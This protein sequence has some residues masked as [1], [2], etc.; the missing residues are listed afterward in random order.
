MTAGA[1]TRGLTAKWRTFTGLPA[2]LKALIGLS[3]VVALGSYM[4]TP[5]IGVLMVKAVGLDIRVAGILVAVATFIQFGGSILGGTVVDRFGLKRTMVLALTLRTAGLVLLGL[6]VKAPWAAYPAVVLVAGGPALYLPANKAYIV[7]HVSD[8]LRPLFLGVSSA[9]LNAGMGLGPLLAALLIDADPVLLLIGLAGLFA[10]I[11]AAHQAAL[12]PVEPR[13]AAAP[14]VAGT[15]RVTGNRAALRGALRPVLFTAL[16]FYLYF[17]F[18]SFM[19]LYAAGVS[20]IQVLGWVM[21]LN[22]AMVVLLQPALAN[23]I[24]RAGYRLLVVGSFALM[25]LGMGAMALGSTPA[26]LAGTALFTFGEIFLFLRCELELVDRVPGNPAFA[27]GVQRLTAGIGGL[28]AGVVGGFVFAH[29]EAA[30]DLGTFW[31]VVAAQCAG[32][33][34]LALL[35]AGGRRPAVPE[36]PV[37]ETA[38]AR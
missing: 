33:A 34:L 38:V 1:G 18:Q 20:N 32:A 21:L 6:A 22:C 16:A 14:A 4:V 30:G 35:L 9:A 8:E 17:F 19:G 28:L 25:A 23:H 37:A 13:P 15:G 31:L 3:F 2:G 24:A 36:L 29:Y 7:T 27:F 12:K 26:L 10:L 5:F 11:T